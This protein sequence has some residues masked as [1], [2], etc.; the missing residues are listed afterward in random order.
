[1]SIAQD[2]EKNIQLNSKMQKMYHLIFISSAVSMFTQQ[3]LHSLLVES[4]LE[5]KRLGITGYCLYRGGN[6][7]QLLEGEEAN[8]KERMHQIAK[9]GLNLNLEVID[10]GYI[11]IRQ[12]NCWTVSTSANDDDAIF[13]EDKISK[14]TSGY[15]VMLKDFIKNMR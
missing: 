15:L 7:I 8:V 13:A 2:L 1:M 5:S 11:E 3:E 4:E 6:L 10:E 12:F 9:T 14:D